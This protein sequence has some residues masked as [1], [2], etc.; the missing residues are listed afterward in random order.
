MQKCSSILKA[1]CYVIWRNYATVT[2]WSLQILVGRYFIAYIIF[3]VSTDWA[4]LF[5]SI[6]C[7][8]NLVYNFAYLFLFPCSSLLTC[9]QAVCFLVYDINTLKVSQV[10]S[11]AWYCFSIRLQLLYN[12]LL[13]RIFPPCSK[14]LLDC[15]DGIHII[16][17]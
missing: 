1:C 13:C 17:L 6:L 5:F 10:A 8:M 9:P 14:N 15:L 11:A 3:W 16:L 4:L 12:I 7:L 2:V